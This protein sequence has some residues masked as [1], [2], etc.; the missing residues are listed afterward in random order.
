MSLSLLK[1]V[2]PL[3]QCPPSLAR[4][5]RDA[6]AYVQ[7]RARKG[8]ACPCCGQRVQL[9]RRKFNPGMGATLIAMWRELVRRDREG[10]PDRWI[11]VEH[12]LVEC[13][14]GPKRS[15][16]FSKM[17]YWGVI[18]PK[19][20]RT[21][22]TGALVS[23]TGYWTVT[24]LGVTACMNLRTPL[25]RKYALDFNNHHHGFEGPEISLAQVF[26]GSRFELK[27]LLAG[28]IE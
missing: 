3:D 7:E 20:R 8:V 5:V 19:A 15:R 17:R 11:H 25:L 1:P 26:E 6:M 27:D 23:D 14:K 21:R 12:D 16:D 28:G 18:E 22:T 10:K 13:G 2:P 4:P 24:H 9:Y